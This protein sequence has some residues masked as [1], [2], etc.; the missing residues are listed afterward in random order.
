MVARGLDT[1]FREAVLGLLAN[2]MSLCDYPMSLWDY[3]MCR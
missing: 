1:H 3:P 2:T